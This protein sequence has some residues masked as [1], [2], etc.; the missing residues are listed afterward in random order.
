VP[1]IRA[2]GTLDAAREIMGAPPN[3]ESVAMPTVHIE[4]YNGRTLEQKT[5]CARA[6]VNAVKEHLGAPPEATQVIFVD[7]EKADWMMGA[8]LAE[9][10]TAR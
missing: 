10:G 5:A 9:G 3:F 8:K 7:V 2:P 1:F 6:V 4:L